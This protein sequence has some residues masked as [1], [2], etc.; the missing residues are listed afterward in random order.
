[1]ATTLPTRGVRSKNKGLAEFSDRKKKKKKEV[2]A[3]E[4]THVKSTALTDA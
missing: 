1:M 2:K 3:S 4:E